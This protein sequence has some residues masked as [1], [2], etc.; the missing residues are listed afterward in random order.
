MFTSL[1]SYLEQFRGDAPVYRLDVSALRRDGYN[2]YRKEEYVVM[3]GNDFDGVSD[4]AMDADDNRH[5]GFVPLKY[6]LP[7]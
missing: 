6:W 7:Y 5:Y 3:S 4:F 2:F 1:A